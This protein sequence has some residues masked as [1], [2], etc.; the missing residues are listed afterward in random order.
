MKNFYGVGIPWSYFFR[1]LNKKLRRG[2]DKKLNSNFDIYLKY[3]K[4]L[5]FT[6]FNLKVL[7]LYFE[8]NLFY[9]IWNI[10]GNDFFFSFKTFCICSATIK[11]TDLLY[12]GSRQGFLFKMDRKAIAK[13]MTFFSVSKYICQNSTR[14]FVAMPN[15]SL[16]TN[17]QLNIFVFE[18]RTS[19][20]T[21]LP[22]LKQSANKSA[23]LG[24]FL[25]E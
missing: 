17:F 6:P 22:S 13:F 18:A 2:Q 21:L 1:K 7:L 9:S 10:Y 24:N 23:Q 25:F 15:S 8:Q 12:L 5:L 14:L 20:Q 11:T 3:F 19:L 4:D 16:P